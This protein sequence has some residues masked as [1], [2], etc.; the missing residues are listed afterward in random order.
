MAGF[1]QPAMTEDSTQSTPRKLPRLVARVCLISVL[2]FIFVLLLG[3]I[4][5]GRG[6]FEAGWYLLVGWLSFL[7]RTVPR[8]AWNWDLIGMGVVC[9]AGILLLTHQFL[10]W[11]VGSI[12][13]K[14]EGE[15]RWPWRWTWCGIASLGVLF[16]VGMAIGGAAH[17]IGWIS[18][19]QEPVMERKPSTSPVYELRMLELGMVLAVEEKT[20]AVALRQFLWDESAALIGSGRDTKR[21]LQDFSVYLI[22]PSNQV[23]GWMIFPRNPGLLEKVG[24]SMH[25]E[26]ETLRLA[27]PEVHKELERLRDVLVPL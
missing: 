3:P 18:S 23:K 26:G 8:I 24:G 19:S 9:G 13:A 20:N 15:V 14:H 11:L 17:Q 4:I 27:A 16:L 12:T 21:L 7:N 10:R 6:Y 5:F 25:E 1:N 2:F 22:A